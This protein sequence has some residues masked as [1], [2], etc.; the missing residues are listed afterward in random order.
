MS[1]I[2]DVKLKEF[3]YLDMYISKL[4]L[5]LIC[6]FETAYAHCVL[7]VTIKNLW[8]IK[9]DINIIDNTRK[10]NIFFSVFLLQYV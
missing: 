4:F 6:L 9:Y 10:T 2:T 1:S 5:E 8:N 3:I 7:H